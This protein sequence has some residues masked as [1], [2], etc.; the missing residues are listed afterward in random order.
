MACLC[1]SMPCNGHAVACN[2]GS[3]VE[4]VASWC[5]RATAV[6]AELHQCQV[7]PCQSDL[8]WSAPVSHVTSSRMCDQVSRDG[9]RVVCLGE[10]LSCRVDGAAGVV[11]PAAAFAVIERCSGRSAGRGSLLA[12][13]PA[14]SRPRTAGVRVCSAI[15]SVSGCVSVRRAIDTSRSAATQR[16]TLR[17]E[18]RTLRR[19]GVQR[20]RAFI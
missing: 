18:S 20:T 5:V 13:F 15:P 8:R 16:S 7:A 1:C 12:P 10:T 4:M 2:G 3:A 6:Q 19:R 11:G 14:R 9:R 17:Y